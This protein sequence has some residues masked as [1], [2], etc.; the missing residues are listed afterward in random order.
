MTDD[1]TI[2][3][4]R[5]QAEIISHHLKSEKEPDLRFIAAHA[6]VLLQQSWA[7]LEERGELKTDDQP[8]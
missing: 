5:Q 8:Q 3:G 4:I 1:H 2:E 7:A 6:E